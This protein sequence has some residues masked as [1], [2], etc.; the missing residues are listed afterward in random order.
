MASQNLNAAFEQAKESSAVHQTAEFKAESAMRAAYF[1]SKLDK[2]VISELDDMWRDMLMVTDAKAQGSGHLGRNPEGYVLLGLGESGTRKTSVFMRAFH[3]MDIFKGFTRGKDNPSFL[4]SVTAP[5]SC[6]LAQLGKVLL[7]GLGAPAE[8]LHR[9]NLIWE[10]L[11]KTLPIRGAIVLHI[12][13]AQHALGASKT[14]LKKVQNAIKGLVQNP[15]WPC[16]VILT[17]LPE[18]ALLVEGDGQVYRRKQVL[19]F[20][21]LDADSD[22]MTIETAVKLFAEKH[23]NLN[24][25][26]LLTEGFIKRL[27]HAS[28]GRLGIAID[29]TRWA[30]LQAYKA[31]SGRLESSH[32]ARAFKRWTGC[33]DEE[34]VFVS[35]CYDQVNVGKFLTRKFIED[36]EASQLVTDLKRIAMLRRLGVKVNV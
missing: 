7:A 22:Q 3:S 6:T 31:N 33:D 36:L 5:S 12:D 10:S 9:E 28:M 34:N 30:V 25:D 1:G 21:L 13:E 20:P 35:R 19:Q 15:T 29:L 18:A 17:G 32:Y 27:I 11:H 4:V 16:W 8:T 26:G 23:G 2:E 24:L 14:D